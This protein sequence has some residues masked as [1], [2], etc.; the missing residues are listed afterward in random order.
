MNDRRLPTVRTTDAG[1]ERRAKR[2]VFVRAAQAL[3]LMVLTF[4]VF[5]IVAPWLI[6]LH[7][8]TALIAA[9]VLIVGV[10]FVIAWFAWGLVQSIRKRSRDH[11]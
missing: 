10:V 5:R 11:G 8:T 6:D 4:V 2:T 7:D 3:G 1:R 9:V